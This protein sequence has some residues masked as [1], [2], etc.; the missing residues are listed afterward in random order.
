MFEA[1]SL[2]DP[3]FSVEIN[4]VYLISYIREVKNTLVLV[5]VVLVSSFCSR[6]FPPVSAF[7]IISFL[8]IGT[9]YGLLEKST[10]SIVSK[11]TDIDGYFKNITLPVP[12]YQNPDFLISVLRL[13]PLSSHKP[14]V[15]CIAICADGSYYKFAFNTKGECTRDTYAQFLQMTDGD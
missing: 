11:Y 3:V 15:S 6:Y 1:T 4:I 7:V 8:F 2:W 14:F 13:T 10:D 9:D 12:V 5:T